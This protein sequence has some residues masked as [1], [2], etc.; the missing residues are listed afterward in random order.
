[1]D[2]KVINVNDI[3]SSVVGLSIVEEEYQ[4]LYVKLSG[5]GRR[6][7]NSIFKRTV[8]IQDFYKE[9][10]LMKQNE[11]KEIDGCGRTTVKELTEFLQEFR[12]RVS[13]RWLST[14]DAPEDSCVVLQDDNESA[15]QPQAN[16]NNHQDTIKRLISKTFSDLSPRSQYPA[17]KFLRRFNEDWNKLYE[18]ISADGFSVYSIYDVGKTT[19]PEIQQWLE[20]VK[21]IIRNNKDVTAKPKT[22]TVGFNQFSAHQNSSRA[23]SGKDVIYALIA[24]K[25][26][27]DDERRFKKL[28]DILSKR[29]R[30]IVEKMIQTSNSNLEQFFQLISDE[31]FSVESIKGIGVKSVLEMYK[32]I[33]GAREIL[34]PY[35]Y[36]ERFN[37]KRVIRVPKKFE[38]LFLFDGFLRDVNNKMSEYR[39]EDELVHIR[40][41]IYPNCHG[42]FK[43]DLYSEIEAFCLGVINQQFSIDIQ[44]R[45]LVFAANN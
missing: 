4:E 33:E 2:D 7:L 39:R 15:L 41:F 21:Y 27:P 38:N 29:S 44:D 9:L 14:E 13:R 35:Y 32:W 8:D 42:V 28:T 36:F 23:T 6:A 5:R 18:R 31:Q 37:L 24:N 22:A 34:K 26:E 25:L 3:V 11:L 10:L 12:Y 17:R 20:R 16:I 1:M 43:E 30:T 19:G 40:D 45:M